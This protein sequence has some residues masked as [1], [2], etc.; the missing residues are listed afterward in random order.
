M[1]LDCAF[2]Q[3]LGGSFDS[4]FM[5]FWIE[6]INTFDQFFL[7]GFKEFLVLVGYPL[8]DLGGRVMHDVK[9]AISGCSLG[10]DARS[11]ILAKVEGEVN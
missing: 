5:L 1:S 4:L 11:F 9:V 6:M 3:K 2:D 8:V 10:K 7:M